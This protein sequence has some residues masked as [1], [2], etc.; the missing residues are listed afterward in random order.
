[1]RKEQR[2]SSAILLT[3]VCFLKFIKGL[4]YDLF[5]A[6]MFLYFDWF[7]S[8]LIMFIYCNNMRTLN[9]EIIE[10]FLFLY[11]MLTYFYDAFLLVW[12]RPKSSKSQVLWATMQEGKLKNSKSTQ[13]FSLENF[14]LKGDKNY[15]HLCRIY[16]I[17]S[18]KIDPNLRFT[19][20]LVTPKKLF[21]TIS[22]FTSLLFSSMTLPYQ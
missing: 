22:T 10:C 14:L 9:L 6:F 21:P 12:L 11:L 17:S 13:V 3:F 7:H 1:M 8:F 19:T 4:T 18:A 20:V 15:T 5:C 2:R 16:S